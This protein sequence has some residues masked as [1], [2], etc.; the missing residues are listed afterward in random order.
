MKNE[1]YTAKEKL[2][3]TFNTIL[4][5]LA[6]VPVVFMETTI[7]LESL[8]LKILFG[9]DIVCWLIIVCKWK[10]INQKTRNLLVVSFGAFLIVVCQWLRVII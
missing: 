9:A 7:V 3:I 6:L 10:K 5:I 4:V 2:F 8:L 1:N